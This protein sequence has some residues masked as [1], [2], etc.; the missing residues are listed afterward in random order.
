MVDDDPVVID[1]LL[2]ADVPCI[3]GDASDLEVL[4]RANADR[5]RIISSTIRRPRDNR[6]LLEFARGV[7]VLVRV[8][9]ERDAGWIREL[10]GVPVVYSEAA[11]EE[12]L[13]WFDNV[14]TPAA[15]R[16]ES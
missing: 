1:R 10:G 15:V 16:R 12:M 6:R 2:E 7:T 8:F 11:A 9:D 14:F 3:R 4:R 5:A 13:K